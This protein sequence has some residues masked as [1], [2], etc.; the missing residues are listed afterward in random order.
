MEL[1]DK[2]NDLSC[3]LDSLIDRQGDGENGQTMAGPVGPALS[4]WQAP[5]PLTPLAAL[6]S[7]HTNIYARPSLCP[8]TLIAS[9]TRK[10]A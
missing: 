8:L 4:I 9:L 5:T 7:L 3:M 10:H 1:A 6:A 2:P